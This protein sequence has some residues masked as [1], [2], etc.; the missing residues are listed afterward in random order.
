MTSVTAGAVMVVVVDIAVDARVVE[1]QASADCK[2]SYF[3]CIEICYV[4][5][6]RFAA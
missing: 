1:V 2:Y 5:G 4:P 3:L 6:E